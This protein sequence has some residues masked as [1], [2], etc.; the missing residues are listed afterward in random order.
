LQHCTE[1]LAVI[2][3]V[4][5]LLSH[6]DGQLFLRFRPFPSAGIVAVRAAACGTTT[7]GVPSRRAP[8]RSLR[9]IGRFRDGA[10]LTELL[11]RPRGF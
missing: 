1:W 3:R 8:V 10:G 5:E 2:D 6:F 9:L 7:A 4:E 11:K